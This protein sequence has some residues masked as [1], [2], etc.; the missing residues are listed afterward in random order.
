METEAAA[1]AENRS[2]APWYSLARTYPLDLQGRTGSF[3]EV[4]DSD[5]DYARC[6]SSLS[7]QLAEIW[8]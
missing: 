7:D 8:L 4:W 2:E 3:H 5:S 1:V 6:F